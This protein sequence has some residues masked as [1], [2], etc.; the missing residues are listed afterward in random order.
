ME[1]PDQAPTRA[2][3]DLLVN[4]SEVSRVR[5]SSLFSYSEYAMCQSD[6]PLT[7]QEK[8]IL[9]RLDTIIPVAEEIHHT[10]ER[11]AQFNF[12]LMSSLTTVLVAANIHLYDRTTVYAP[13][14]VFLLL[15][16]L[17]FI[18]VVVSCLVAVIPRNRP[19]VTI[20]PCVESMKAWCDHST[21]EYMYQVFLSYSD[22]WKRNNAALTAKTNATQATYAFVIAGLVCAILE[23]LSLLI[24]VL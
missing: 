17:F 18:G 16:L 2:G 15:Y 11:K 12:A 1:E 4:C 23:V 9:A 8:H 13:T 20:T 24:S 5:Q 14:V 10:L 22:A 19:V 21:D 7:D 6:R 3:S